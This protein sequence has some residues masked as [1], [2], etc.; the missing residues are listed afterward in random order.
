MVAI[1]YLKTLFGVDNFL[2][3]Q[4]FSFALFI[5]ASELDG[6]KFWI[7]SIEFA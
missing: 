5:I 3:G 2:G 6:E 1:Y 7:S 4:K